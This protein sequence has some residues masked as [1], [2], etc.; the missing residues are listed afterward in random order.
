MRLTEPLTAEDMVVQTISDVSPTKWHLAHVTWWFERFL[1]VEFVP[2]YQPFHPAYHDLFNSYYLTVGTPWTRSMRGE[3]SRPTV[4]EV[5]DYRRAVDA[6][7][8]DLIASVGEAQRGRV[9]EL[10]RLGLQHEEQHQEL[11]LMDI[12]HVFASNPLAPKYAERPTEGSAAAPGAVPELRWRAVPGGVHAVGVELGH[13]GFCYDNETP[14]HEVLLHDA[15]IA[16]RLVTNGEFAAFIADGGYTTSALWLSDGW[17]WLRDEA[18]EAPLYWRRPTADA[19][20]SEFT[21]HGLEPLDAAAPVIHVSYYEADAFARWAGARL[22]TEFEWEATATGVQE[23]NLAA[24]SLHPRGLDRADEAVGQLHSEA[25]QWTASAYAPYPGFRP[26]EGAL[27]EYNGKFMS[28]TMV[29]RGSACV[30]P[31]G[32]SR[33]SYRNFYHP[34]QR[35]QFGGLRLARNP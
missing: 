4:A 12:K 11:L 25:W 26:L 31:R 20:W 29:L 19:P 8:L 27:G 17:D 14:R 34:R 9:L 15:E 21:L 28:S 5:L 23:S 16:D 18:V 13:A 35:W 3:L 22:P 32:H 24:P 6:A 10:V 30:T 1:L 33:S 7:V 2:G